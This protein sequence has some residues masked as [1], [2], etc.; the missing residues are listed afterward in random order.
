[1]LFHICLPI[2]QFL[3]AKIFSEDTSVVR[4]YGEMMFMNFGS[5]FP[6][7]KLSKIMA[8]ITEPVIGWPITVS[9]W[10]HL[11]IA[12]KRKLCQTSFDI[13]EQDMSTAIHATL[14]GHSPITERRIYGLSPDSMIGAS[15]DVFHLYLEASTEWQK[16]FNIV[17]GGLGLPYSKAR[18]RCFDNLVGQGIIKLSKQQ[19]K[20]QA[21]DLIIGNDNQMAITLLQQ[22]QTRAAKSEEKMLANQEQMILHLQ[23]LTAQVI[24]MQKEMLD[25]RQACK[26]L[27][28]LDL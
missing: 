17:P 19:R 2:L 25:L 4:K 21:T 10:R 3:A 22:V 11:N 18:A 24:T 5:E 13:F 20:H 1:M 12:W 9:I 14:A 7:D 6:E 8:S 23:T 26:Q 15:E 16:V 27:L 28:Y